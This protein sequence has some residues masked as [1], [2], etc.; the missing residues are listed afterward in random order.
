MRVHRGLVGPSQFA[1]IRRWEYLYD[2]A[3]ESI[4]QFQ[5]ESCL[6]FCME[7]FENS[8]RERN[9]RLA[10]WGRLETR[11]KTKWKRVSPGQTIYERPMF[12]WWWLTKHKSNGPGRCYKHMLVTQLFAIKPLHP[13]RPSLSFTF[14]SNFTHPCRTVGIIILLWKCARALCLF[15]NPLFVLAFFVSFLFAR[16]KYKFCAG[17]MIAN[18]WIKFNIIFNINV[19]TKQQNDTQT[20]QQI[21]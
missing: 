16:P 18:N 3:F 12:L 13:P 11:A 5:I 6:A 20:N 10:S 2:S 21:N 9:N 17:S 1:A 8:L 4:E 7:S 14:P 19:K 15:S